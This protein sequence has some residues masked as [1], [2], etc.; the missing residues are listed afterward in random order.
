MK[1]LSDIRLQYSKISVSIDLFLFGGD[2]FLS[3]IAQSVVELLSSHVR[4]FQRDCWIYSTI[5]D[6]RD[7]REEFRHNISAMM[8]KI[9]DNSTVC[10]TAYLAN[11]KNI[12]FCQI[13]KTSIFVTYEV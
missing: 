8:T 12:R 10:A 2:G 3:N 1:K 11:T 6:N 4:K 7:L 13:I 5:M 9:I